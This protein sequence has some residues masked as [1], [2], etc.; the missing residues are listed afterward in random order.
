MTANLSTVSAILQNDDRE[1]P[2]FADT[3]KIANLKS[4]E[5]LLARAIEFEAHRGSYGR[6]LRALLPLR[7]RSARARTNERIGIARAGRPPS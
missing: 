1:E 5:T 4:Y 6:Q 2:N 3:N 7:S